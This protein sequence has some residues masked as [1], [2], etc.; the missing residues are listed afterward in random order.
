M[1]TGR[2]VTEKLLYENNADAIFFLNDMM[3]FGAIH[4]IQSSGKTIGKDISMI[5]FDNTKMSM[6]CDP[7]LSTVDS[8]IET[9][10]QRYIGYILDREVPDEGIVA[11]FIKRSSSV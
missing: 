5:G 7:P 8:Q 2:I 9:E 3:A 6:F 1:E 4:T 11:K 10:I